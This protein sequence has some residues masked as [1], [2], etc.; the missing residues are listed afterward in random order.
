MSQYSSFVRKIVYGSAIVVLLF[1]LFLLGQPATRSTAEGGGGSAGGILAQMRSSY[2]LSQAELGK[3]DPASETMKMA[4]LGLRGVATNLLWTKANEYKRTESWD[5]LS[6]TLNQIVKLQPNYITVWEFQAHNLSYNISAEFDDYRM[7]YHWVKKGIEFLIE[8]TRYNQRNPRLF[9][10]LGWFTGHKIGRPDEYVQFRRMFRDD[11]DFH[12]T[13]VDFINID[14]ARG[15]G[16][17]DQSVVDNWKVAYLWYKQSQMV[18]DKG[19]PVTWMRI[20]VDKEGYTDKRR[21][22]VIFYSDPSMA[23]IGHADAITNEITPGEKTRRAWQDAGREWE[24]FGAMD[25]PTTFGHTVRLNSVE[26]VRN[27]EKRFREKLEALAPDLREEI[28]RQR[29]ETLTPEELAAFESTKSPQQWTEDEMAAYSRAYSKLTV[30]DLDLADAMPSDLRAQARYYAMQATE[31][32]VLS[33]RVSAYATVVN[34]DYWKTRCE[35][36]QSKVTADARR[37]MM[38]ADQAAERGDPEGA[39]AEYEKAWTEWAQIFTQYP[40]L[41]NDTMADDLNEV[42][43]R[44]KLVLDQLDEEF[45]RDFKLQMLMNQDDE[46][47]RKFPGLIPEREGLPESTPPAEPDRDPPGDDEPAGEDGSSGGD[48]GTAAPES[49]ESR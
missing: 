14:A 46:Q 11:K 41:I 10:N 47:A 39:R 25:I 37:Y 30:S 33:D 31:T 36:E 27:D 17:D 15:P 26:Q 12:D 44:Y 7:R 8:G 48:D 29:R 40:Q 21:S 35:V 16:P 19:V 2:G 22:S 24:R 32:A 9:W 34:Y 1:P 20:D 45:P 38:F 6:A 13:M 3:I 49:D 23:L 28:R 42:I 43:F 18:V 5:R 4:T